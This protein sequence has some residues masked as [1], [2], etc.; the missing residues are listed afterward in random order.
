MGG[1]MHAAGREGAWSGAALTAKHAGTAMH[2]LLFALPCVLA[3]SAG[4]L[5]INTQ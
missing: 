1:S 4:A 5:S 2:I 3:S